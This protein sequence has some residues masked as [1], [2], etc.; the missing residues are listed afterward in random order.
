L[1]I[2]GS[3][4]ASTLTL[5]STS[6]SGTTDAIIG[7]TGSSQVE[8]FRVTT[9][10]LF[11]IGPNV[12]PDSKLTVNSNTAATVAPLLPTDIHTIAADGANGG[13]LHD[14]YGGGV[15]TFGRM[16]GGTQASKTATASDTGMSFV[17]QGWDTSAYVSMASIDMN[18]QDVQTTTD[19]SGYIQFRTVSTVASSALS[20]KMRLTAIGGLNL[21]NT[22][23][24]LAASEFGM[25]KI[26]ASGSAP[27]AGTA[28]LAVVAGTTGGSC[29]L[30]MYAGTSTT[31]TTI[32]DNVGSGC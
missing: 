23:A 8:R 20:Q 14:V 16:A 29:K 11:N 1:H 13:V 3:G 10:G 19:H 15:F 6:G 28:K 26:A 2:G 18:S 4:A 27:G 21:G 25:N 32:I 5:Q 17:A 31:P 12:A 9:G 30:I 7:Q 22:V 24:A